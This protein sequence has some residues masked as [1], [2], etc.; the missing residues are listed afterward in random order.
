M[1][2][3]EAIAKR[4]SVRSYKDRALEPEQIEKLLEAA[5][6][7]PSARNEQ[8]W[9]IVVVT[10]PKT[11]RELQHACME[12]AQLANADVI[13]C[14][15]I[16][17]PRSGEKDVYETQVIDLT[18]A[19]SF[20]MLQA[21]EMELGSC[22][23]GDFNPKKVKTLLRI[24]DSQTVVGLLTIGFPHYNPPASSRKNR[25]ELFA[26]DIFTQNWENKSD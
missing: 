3:S 19:F 16:G 2:V 4:R 10:N 17:A 13:L 20:V 22:W 24:P 15:C 21:V 23:I 6:L 9:R 14:G 7:A 25:S 18:I 11:R 12:Q 5:R 26:R 1:N 8:P